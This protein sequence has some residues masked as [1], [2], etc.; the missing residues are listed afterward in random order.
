MGFLDSQ[1]VLCVVQ[2]WIRMRA[3]QGGMPKP[4]AVELVSALKG[5]GMEQLLVRLHREVGTSGD[6]WVVRHPPG[7]TRT[8]KFSC[9]FY[10]FN[11]LCLCA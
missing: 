6:V 1:L 4:A 5:W 3:K 10:S 2:K 8:A 9:V 7:H 11:P